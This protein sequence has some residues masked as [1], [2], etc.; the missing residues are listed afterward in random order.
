[1][2]SMKSRMVAMKIKMKKNRV[3]D[4]II[5]PKYIRVNSN[6]GKLIAFGKVFDDTAKIHLLNT[7]RI[8]VNEIVTIE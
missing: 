4:R 8:M 2:P 1:M 5:N 6:G 3:K 7:I